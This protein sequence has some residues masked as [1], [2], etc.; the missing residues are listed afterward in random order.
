[1]ST[2]AARVDPALLQHLADHY[3][4]LPG[5]A[6]SPRARPPRAATAD[7]ALVLR[8][9]EQ[10]LPHVNLPACARCHSSGKRA[11]Y[12]VL[13]GQ[14]SEYMA[15]RLR[16]WRGEANVVEA[17]KPNDSMSMIARRI[18]ESL[19]EPLSDYYAQHGR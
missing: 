2:A 11:D 5:L 19:I 14:K 9:V 12:P 18:P 8:T 1:M 16:R 3:A 6:D 15:A 17:R 10:G 7:E 4:N 13:F